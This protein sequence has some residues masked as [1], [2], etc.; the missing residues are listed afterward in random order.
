MQIA[1]MISLGLVVHNWSRAIVRTTTVPASFQTI[2]SG[3]LRSFEG[4]DFVLWRNFTS[5]YEAT[6][7]P[8]TSS[9]NFKVQLLS[10]QAPETTEIWMTDNLRR[11]KIMF[12]LFTT[13]NLIWTEKTCWV[14]LALGLPRSLDLLSLFWM[15]K[16]LNDLIAILLWPL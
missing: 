12:R 7:I 1:I 16:R 5:I 2:C 10:F 6:S 14:R 3:S 11:H 15:A 4:K 8:K 13:N 9:L